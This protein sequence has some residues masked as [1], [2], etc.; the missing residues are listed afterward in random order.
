[1]GCEE[2]GFGY[3]AFKRRRDVYLL[4]AGSAHTRILE[5]RWRGSVLF[6][7]FGERR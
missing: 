3:S 7:M 5:L 1:M 4:L 6:T 2:D